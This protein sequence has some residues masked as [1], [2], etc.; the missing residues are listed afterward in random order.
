[1]LD[2]K[3]PEQ[4]ISFKLWNSWCKSNQT[5][6]P[7][8]QWAVVCF[9]LLA[10]STNDVNIKLKCIACIVV[11][12]APFTEH[13]PNP[14]IDFLPKIILLVPSCYRN[15]D[16]L[17]STWWAAWLVCRLYIFTFTS[18]GN[19][20]KLINSN[21]LPRQQFLCAHYWLRLWLVSEKWQTE[22]REQIWTWL[23]F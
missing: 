19:L 5:I 3:L 16:K 21:F 7:P 13:V 14:A 9:I 11:F 8:N 18:Y 20:K 15:R 12:P 4:K 10:S 22:S 2:K 17:R 6:S 1:M 23:Y